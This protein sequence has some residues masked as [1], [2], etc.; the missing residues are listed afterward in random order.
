MQFINGMMLD[1]RPI[2]TD[3]DAGY[4]EGR[5]FGRARSGGQIRDD[6]RADYDEGRGG[7]GKQAPEYQEEETVRAGGRGAGAGASTGANSMPVTAPVVTSAAE[8]EERMLAI[9]A[10]QSDEA[11]GVPVE[12][13]KD[14]FQAQNWRDDMAVGSGTPGEAAASAAAAEVGGKRSRPDEDEPDD[15]EASTKNPRFRSEEEDD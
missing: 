10:A 7:W 15:A 14:A 12:Q 2:R 13:Y 1:D 5:E 3:I 4:K 6:Q 11:S 8:A 9:K